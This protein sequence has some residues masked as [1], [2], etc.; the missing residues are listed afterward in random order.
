MSDDNPGA[1]ETDGT[2]EPATMEREEVLA[3]LDDAMDEAHHK[4]VSGRVYDVDNEKTRQGWFRTLGYLA[5]QYRSLKKDSELEEFE[6]RLEAVE[7]QQ[8]GASDNDF[9]LK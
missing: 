3:L 4:V 2:D 9:Q 5:N 6:E 7:A 1:D 8:N